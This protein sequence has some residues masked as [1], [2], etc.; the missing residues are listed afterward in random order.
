MMSLERAVRAYKI[1]CVHVMSKYDDK[2]MWRHDSFLTTSAV[3]DKL[4]ALRDAA[5]PGA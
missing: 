1:G 3:L 5:A 4:D 2:G